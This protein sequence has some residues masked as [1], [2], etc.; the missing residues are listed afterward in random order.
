MLRQAPKRLRGLLDA[1]RTITSDLPLVDMLERIVRAACELVGSRYGALGVIG[2]DDTLEQFVHYGMDAETVART[3][4]LL[5]GTGLLDTLIADP[6][7]TGCLDVAIRVRD[8]VYGDLYL[9]VPESGAFSADDEELVTALAATAGTAIA[10]ARLYEDARRSRDWLHASG[11]ITRALLADA[12]ADMLLEVVSRALHVA[13]ADYGALV[14]PVANGRLLQVAV[15]VGVGT[16]R[17]DGHV[18]DPENSAMAKAMTTGE[19]LVLNDMTALT[20]E[21]F[22]NA[23]NYGPI[24]LA[25]LVDAKGVR[26]AVLLLRTANHRPFSSRDLDLATTFADQV[27]LALE[28]DDARNDAEWLRVLEVRHRIDE[29]LHDNVIQRLFATG[30]GLQGL[31]KAALPTALADRLG[32]HISDLDD[33]INEI[34]DRVFGLREGAADGAQRIRGRFPH[35]PCATDEPRPADPSS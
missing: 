32:R 25:P 4:A 27:A 35:V 5:T 6:E 12:D 19:G 14:L 11:E 2:A 16:D 30:V 13:E 28:M 24:M 10:N 31:A 8:E 18:F 15:A 20:A 21:G 1:H 9:S 17:F 3:G 34:R 26:G 22:D 23:E 29:D 33:T 7:M